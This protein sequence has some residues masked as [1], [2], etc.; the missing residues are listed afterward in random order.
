MGVL[1]CWFFV[2]RKKQTQ[3]SQTTHMV[4]SPYLVPTLERIR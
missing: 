3:Q 1:R 4:F 2:I